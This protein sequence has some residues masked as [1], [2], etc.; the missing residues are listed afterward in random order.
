M[1][2]SI[3]LESEEFGPDNEFINDLEIEKWEINSDSIKCL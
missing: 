2:F 3:M 1:I